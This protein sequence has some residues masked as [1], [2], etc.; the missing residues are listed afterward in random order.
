MKWQGSLLA[1]VLVSASAWAQQ[2]VPDTARL[3]APVSSPQMAPVAP[4]DCAVPGL[5]SGDDSEG[6]AGGRL[7]S[8]RTFSN[9][10][11]FIS[12]P[13]Q[14]IDPRSLTQICPIFLSS[15]VS[16]IPALPSGDGQVY[17]PA[18]SVAL[19]DRLCVGMN[20]GGYARLDFNGNEPGLFRDRFGKLHDRRE[21]ASDREGWLNLGGF[22]QYTL[23]EDVPNQFLLTGGMRIEVPSGSSA[24][25]Q[26]NGPAHLAPYAT[27]GKEFGCFHVLATGGYQFPT[28]SGDATTDLF[29][30]N[31]HLDRQTFG[32][33]YPLVEL[34]CIYHTT[35]VAVDLP[36]RRGLIDFGNFESSGNIVTLSVGANAVIVRNHLEFGAVYTTSLA[37][38]RDLNVDGLLVKM[39]MR[40]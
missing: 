21:F 31:L 32:W 37:T 7:R 4:A 1:S 27:V 34:N 20:Q 2:P 18:I 40:Y 36:T 16:P 10:I 26:G 14:S 38:Q 5:F 15:W 28:G 39:V 24:I 35:S 23:I 29:Y 17:G 3:G 30:L 13:L 12:N 11:G 9:F 19:S 8:N 6:D 33:L 25:F 22:F